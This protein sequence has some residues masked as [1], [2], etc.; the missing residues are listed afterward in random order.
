MKQ[1][2]K[3]SGTKPLDLALNWSRRGIVIALLVT[4]IGT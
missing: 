2:L 1:R 3:T 4:P